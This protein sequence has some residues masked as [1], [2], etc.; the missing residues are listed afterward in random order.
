VPRNCGLETLGRRVMD[1]ELGGFAAAKLP[2][3][4]TLINNRLARA[5]RTLPTTTHLR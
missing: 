2:T 5:K 3:V 1:N 4:K